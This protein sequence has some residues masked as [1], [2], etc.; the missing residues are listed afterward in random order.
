MF[1]IGDIV[2]F[3]RD[4]IWTDGL[5]IRKEYTVV[6][7][8]TALDKQFIKVIKDGLWIEAALFDLVNQTGSITENTST[9]FD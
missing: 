1:K 2:R 7:A 8:T 4:G 9:F 5:S 6:N 3:V